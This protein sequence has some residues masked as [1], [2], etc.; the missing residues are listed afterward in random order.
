[1]WKRSITCVRGKEIEFQ[2]GTTREREGNQIPCCLDTII[3]GKST[4]ASPQ[5][6]SLSF[7]SLTRFP[8]HRWGSWISS[9]MTLP[10]FRSYLNFYQPSSVQHSFSSLGTRY[11]WDHDKMGTARFYAALWNSAVVFLLLNCYENFGELR[12]L[13]LS[14]L[15]KY[16]R[17]WYPSTRITLGEILRV[18]SMYAVFLFF[19]PC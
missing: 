13:K 17:D 18:S 12:W 16:W 19:P 7:C 14:M 10:L 4:F 15:C 9:C 6:C 11:D 3:I 1:M 2:T 8:S 5:C